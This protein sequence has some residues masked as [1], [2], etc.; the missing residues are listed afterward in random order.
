MD[1][2]F[3]TVLIFSDNLMHFYRT[4]HGFQTFSDLFRLNIASDIAI[5]VRMQEIATILKEC[6][7]VGCSQ[8]SHIAHNP[9][10]RVFPEINN[11]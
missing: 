10:F 5:W 8:T 1:V 6:R 2:H 4:T 7:N 11:V 9:A 3:E